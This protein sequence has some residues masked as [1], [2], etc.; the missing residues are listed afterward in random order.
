[1]EHYIGHPPYAEEETIMERGTY[2][3]LD[4]LGIEYETVR[5]KAAFT[6][7][8]CAEVEKNL[9]YLHARTFF[10]ATGSRHSSTCSCFRGKRFSR[11]SSFH[12]SWVVPGFPLPMKVT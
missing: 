6:M 9:A 1:M 12:P 4:T 5:H 8:D 11:Q 10:S 3:F 2:L 7:D